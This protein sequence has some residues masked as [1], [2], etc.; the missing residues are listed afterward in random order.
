[1]KLQPP[2]TEATDK[3]SVIIPHLNQPE[4]LSKCLTSLMSQTIG[5][6]RVE[7]IVVDNGSRELPKE[8]VATFQNTILITQAE[9]G[10]G[11]ARNKGV[12]QS[13]GSILA[14][15]DS[16]C[17][18]DTDWLA[19]ISLALHP[20]R[21]NA[22]VG[23][24]VKIATIVAG[25]PNMVEA[26]EQVFS[27]RQKFYVEIQG[28]SATLNMATRRNVFE[29]VGPFGGIEIAEDR[30]WGQRAAA[31]G[32]KTR[33][34]P[35]ILVTHPARSNIRDI[36]AKWDRLLSHDYEVHRKGFMGQ[37]KWFLKSIALAASPLVSA[38]NVL[39]STEL[40][41]LRDRL[42]AVSGLVFVRL[43][44]TRKMLSLQFG[45]RKGAGGHSWNRG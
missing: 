37:V 27:F 7:I 12:S 32:L 40:H 45:S 35:Q 25:K 11:P 42:L 19:Q 22:I 13:S 17:V 14:F 21:G 34:I 8:L 29:R 5:M 2:L 31:L 23:G 16:D 10:P 3:I 41:S 43:Y 28:Y 20:D 9:P 18:A 30:D 15:I 33:F 38:I 6:E 39:K 36:C 4:Y 1:M 44:R 24:A 26:Y